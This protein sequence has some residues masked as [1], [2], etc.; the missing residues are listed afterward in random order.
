MTLSTVKYGL[1]A[2]I[3]GTNARFALVELNDARPVELLDQRTLPTADF[4]NVND[5]VRHYLQTGD[6]DQADVGSGSFAVAGAVDGDWFELT[7]SPW[8]FSTQ[9]VCTELGFSSLHLLNDFAAIAWSIPGLKADE[10]VRVGGGEA[11]PGLPVAVLGP[12]TGLGIGGFILQ[13]DHF[14]VIQTE[15][16]HASFAPENGQEIEILRVLSGKFGHVSWERILSGP[17][18]ENLYEAM[19]SVHSVQADI[20]TAREITQAALQ[21]G[22]RFCVDVLNQFCACLG[23]LA[24]DVALTLGAR[25]GVN[26]AGGIVPR[27]VDFFIASPFR[28]RFEMKGR[29]S[30]YNAGIETRLVIAGQPGLLGAA[31]H[32]R[33]VRRL[34][35]TSGSALPTKPFLLSST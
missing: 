25:G 14:T 19:L 34:A 3:G 4:P 31:A 35:A 1:V 29:F 24:G 2:D 30:D 12:G 8:A 10:F 27:F 23:S 18:L 13:G 17:G 15:G 33:S 5:A 9:A 6:Y 20:L 28:Q 26:I 11:N 21:D 32:Q 22:E 16:G 7:N